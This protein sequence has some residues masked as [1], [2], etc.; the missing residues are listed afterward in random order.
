MVYLVR[1][2]F[3]IGIYTNKEA[4]N[5]YIAKGNPTIRKYATC[6]EAKKAF[7]EEISLADFFISW[8]DIRRNR[9]Y[10]IYDDAVY[11]VVY[12]RS[13][14]GFTKTERL[15]EF[16]AYY[17]VGRHRCQSRLTYKEAVHYMW[18]S[19]S[20]S[21]GSDRYSEEQDPQ[22]GRFYRRNQF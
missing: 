10:K 18:Y 22:S 20:A 17:H 4:L 3:C 2:T 7:E 12:T 5:F 19:L 6:E 13:M 21:R 16:L 1:T 9:L 15:K 11:T 8:E 14:M